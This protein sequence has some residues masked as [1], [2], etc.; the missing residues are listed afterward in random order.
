MS[1][2]RYTRLVSVTVIGAT[3]YFL[4][5]TWAS[6]PTNASAKLSKGVEP[7]SA[8]SRIEP[9]QNGEEKPAEQVYKN[10][11]VLKGMPASE[12]NSVMSFMAGW[13]RGN[14]THRAVKS[15]ERGGH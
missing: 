11:L 14:L 3:L 4:V 2:Q 12:L 5:A 10:I 1:N 7:T 8:A 13:A 15:R 9:G 6:D